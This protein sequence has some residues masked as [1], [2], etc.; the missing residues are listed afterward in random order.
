ML[1]N[2]EACLALTQLILLYDTCSALSS[3]PRY[4]SALSSYGVP[5]CAWRAV[6]R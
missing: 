1:C 2:A 4:H 3:T 5:G 6:F